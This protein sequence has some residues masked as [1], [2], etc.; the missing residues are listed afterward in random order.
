MCWKKTK[1]IG[2]KL[3]TENFVSRKVPL[4]FVCIVC[5]KTSDSGAVSSVLMLM[6]WIADMRKK[7]QLAINCIRCLRNCYWEVSIS[8]AILGHFKNLLANFYFYDQNSQS[9]EVHSSLLKGQIGLQGATAWKAF[10]QPGALLGDPALNFI[11]P[12]FSLHSP[13]LILSWLNCFPIQIH[14]LWQCLTPLFSFF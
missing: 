11:P 2:N 7:G 10:M 12:W 14:S 3:H 13:C 6:S 9:C 5:K 1:N 4:F 8:N